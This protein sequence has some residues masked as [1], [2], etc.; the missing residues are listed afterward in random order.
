MI[1]D[2]AAMVDI[3]RCDRARQTGLQA[4]LDDVARELVRP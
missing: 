1:R 4:F 2:V 3:R